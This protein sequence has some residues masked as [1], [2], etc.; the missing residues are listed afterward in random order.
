MKKILK[1]FASLRITV[2]VLIA[3][4]MLVLAGTLAQT[5]MPIREAQKI[6]FQSFV[7][8]IHLNNGMS[9]PVLPGGYTLGIIMIFNL[10]CAYLTTFKWSFKR[11]GILIMHSGILLLLLGQL[12]TDLYSVESQMV[13]NHGDAK[14]YTEALYD[15]ELVLIDTSGKDVDR[16][17]S[18]PQ[19]KI[20]TGNM[21]ADSRLPIAISVK[22]FI[23]NANL[24]MGVNTIATQGFGQRVQAVPAPP[25]KGDDKR[26]LRCAYV[27]LISNG[28]S[29]G[30]WMLST[31]FMKAD[32]IEIDGKTYDIQMRHRRYMLPMT[33]Q[34]QEFEH[35]RF[36]GTNVP[37]AFS[38]RVRLVDPVQHEDRM[39]TISMNQPLR[40][41]GKTFYQAGFAN[42]DK[43]TILQVVLNPAAMLPYIA[44]ILV[45]L[46][47]TWHFVAHFIKF[48][49]QQTKRDTEVKA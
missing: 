2:V 15:F 7:V 36:T 9:I 37:A 40:Y 5:H 27:D 33:I 42:E 16:V 12:F 41:A 34:L 14:N 20:A 3:G 38:S 6:Y 43:T 29:L 28:K 19:S 30:T 32:Q 11:M 8:P 35:K 26:N 25:V 24:T 22:E 4:M 46:G 21:I 45:T 17:Y 31:A 47:M 23:T 1:K 10:T 18:I 39:I 48:R 13:L 44:C 49:K